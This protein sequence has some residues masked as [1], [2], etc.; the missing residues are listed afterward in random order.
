MIFDNDNNE[1]VVAVFQSNNPL[2]L[3]ELLQPAPF[4]FKGEGERG[5]GTV[6]TYMHTYIHTYLLTYLQHVVSFTMELLKKLHNCQTL[7]RWERRRKKGKRE[8][9]KR[10]EK[11]EFGFLL[12]TVQYSTLVL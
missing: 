6:Y 2:K 5:C 7:Q 12:C 8:N 4:F 9:N 11:R 10:K 1:A 3:A